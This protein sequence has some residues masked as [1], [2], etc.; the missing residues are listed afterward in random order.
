MLARPSLEQ[1]KN[2]LLRIPGGGGE[3][4]EKELRKQKGFLENVGR[5]SYPQQPKFTA[6]QVDER[7]GRNTHT[8]SAVDFVWQGS[9]PVYPFPSTAAWAKDCK[10]RPSLIEGRKAEGGKRATQWKWRGRPKER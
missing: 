7:I 5:I 2:F 4:G 1:W 6:S 3:E 10:K 9:S 8:H